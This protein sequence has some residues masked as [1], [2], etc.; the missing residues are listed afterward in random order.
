MAVAC[1]KKL[2]T[3]EKLKSGICEPASKR[4]AKTL[5]TPEKTDKVKGIVKAIIV[6]LIL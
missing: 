2:W 6:F 3:T 1:A 4:N 5:L